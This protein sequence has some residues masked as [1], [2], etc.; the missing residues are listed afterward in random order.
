MGDIRLVNSCKQLES[1]KLLY[2]VT[3]IKITLQ[4]T[5]FYCADHIFLLFSVNY[6]P[7]QERFVNT[8]RYKFYSRV[9]NLVKASNQNRSYIWASWV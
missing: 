4:L 5:L 9:A 8:R 7:W 2:I 6:K 1:L 3:N